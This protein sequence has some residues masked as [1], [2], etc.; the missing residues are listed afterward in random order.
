V[1]G[2]KGEPLHSW[3]VLILPFIEEEPLYDL[4]RLDEP[5]D[6][7]H[8]LALLPRMPAAY[9][10]PPG[11]R[12][13]VPQHNTVCKVFVGPGAAFEGHEGLRLSRD[14]IDG[15]SRTFLV[16]EAGEPIAWTKPMDLA[17]DPNGPLPDL[18]CLFDDGFRAAMADGSVR[19][20]RKGIRETTVRALVTRNGR[21]TLGDDW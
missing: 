19:F 12:S 18:R 8:N 17:F 2:S 13:G 9:A 10:P 3:R 21:E 4:F 7:T 6:S 5:W 20:I 14:F 16:V 15:R 11:K 1:Y